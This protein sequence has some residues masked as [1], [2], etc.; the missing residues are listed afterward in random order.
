MTV[1]RTPTAEHLDLGGVTL[2]AHPENGTRLFPDGEVYVQLEEVAELTEA[3]VVH[4]GAPH[5]NRG[6]AY[7]YGLL[8]LLR[9]HDVPTTVCFTYMPYSRQ[10]ASFHDGTLNHA[11]HLID[12]L[13]RDGAD[14]VYAVDPHCGHH[15]WVPAAF[16]T[17]NA[18]PLL[19]DAV[20]MD[21]YVIVGPDAGAV[22][23][24]GIPG[25]E[26]ERRN[27]TD[28]ELS[29]EMDVAGRDVLVFDDIIASGNTM[30]AAYDRVREQGADRVE[31]AAVHGVLQDGV[32]RVADTFD[33][34]H[35]TNTVDREEATVDVT[36]LL[37]K[38]L[39][40]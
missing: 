12:R 29:G 15:D 17:I 5:P 14:H 16:T 7:L 35:L 23:R 22:D 11:R 30:V 37:A 27:S 20:D 6:L 9:E 31:A 2:A 26:K 39:D 36:P 24:F 3:V 34:L 40:L 18:Y 21:E 25:F 1:I 33:A 19:R 10:D 32:E 38:R 28:I 4:G 13:L 8:D